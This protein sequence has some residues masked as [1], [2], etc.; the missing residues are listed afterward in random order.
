MRVGMPLSISSKGNIDFYVEQLDKKSLSELI[1]DLEKGETIKIPRDF[2]E[3]VR[4][5]PLLAISKSDLL[6]KDYEA[7]LKWLKGAL[8]L[9]SKEENLFE[10]PRKLKYDPHK[11]EYVLK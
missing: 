2:N 3:G 7:V 4:T 8:R 6:E 10:G 9:Y 11:K 5:L 1:D